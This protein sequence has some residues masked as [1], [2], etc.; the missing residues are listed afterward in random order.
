MYIW[1][2]NE[3]DEI[4]YLDI[5]ETEEE[6][7]EDAI[8]NYN[9]MP[10]ETIFIGKIYEYVPYPDVDIMLERM[11]NDAYEECGDVTDWW[12]ISNRK[13]NPEAFDELCEKVNTAV[14]EYLKKIGMMPNFYKIKDVHK[15][16]I[17]EEE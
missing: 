2:E 16:I 14:D 7:V 17:G 13:Y 9:M 10:G 12:E 15:V 6:C 11:E 4:W 5:F 8:K 1:N 3:H